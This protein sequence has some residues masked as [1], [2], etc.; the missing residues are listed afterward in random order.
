MNVSFLGWEAGW[1]DAE[2]VPH[3]GRSSRGPLF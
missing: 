1:S 2:E 3:M